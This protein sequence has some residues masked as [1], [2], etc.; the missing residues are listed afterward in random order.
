MD[1]IVDNGNTLVVVE[2]NVDVILRADWLIDM[3]PYGGKNGGS[4]VYQ[5]EPEG[6][7]HCDASITGRYLRQYLNQGT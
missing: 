6:I 5:G 2:H 3:G 7:L 1:R 4:I